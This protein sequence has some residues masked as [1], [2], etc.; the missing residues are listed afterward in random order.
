MKKISFY[1]KKYWYLYLLA[2]FCLFIYEFLDMVSPKVTQSIID[3]VITDGQTNLLPILI[4]TLVVV[5]VGRVAAG[6]VREFTFDKTS[7]KVASDIRKHLFGHVQSL[8]VD[9][10]DKMNTGEIMSRVKDD[11]DKLQGAFGFIGMMF[12]QVVIHTV[13]ILWCMWQISP[14]LTIFPIIA[15]PLC[16]TIAIVME[17]KL[18]KVYEEISD[19]DADMN[20]V[21]EENLTG[22]RVVKAFAREKFEIT[23]FLKHNKRYYDLNM[24]QS[25]VWIKYN[26]LM[27][28]MTKMLIVVALLL[29]GLKVINGEMS[30]GALGAF[31]EYCANAVWP[32]EMLGWLSN[33]LASAFASKK[34]LDKIYAETAKIRDPEGE[35]DEGVKD[36]LENFEFKN[37]EFKNVSFSMENKKILENVSFKLEKGRTLGIMGATGSGKTTIINMLL[38]FYDPEKGKILLNGV[39]IRELPLAVVRRNASVVMQ[40]V[41]LFSDTIDENIR[42]GNKDGITNDDISEALKKACASGFVGKLEEGTETVIGERGVGLSG[43]QKQR[44][45]M[46]RAFAKHAPVLVLDDST[47]ALDMETEHEVQ[48]NLSE[49]K[50]STKIIIAHRISAVRHADEIIVL[51]N[52]KIS[53]RGNHESLLDKKGYYY[54]T[55]M[56]QYGDVLKQ[57][58]NAN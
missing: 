15:L 39:D 23:K 41:F 21:A 5:G 12:L 48:E 3:D 50:N 29:G 19:E 16:A 35:P 26:P 45:S 54:K 57:L 6:Y 32:M 43:G 2:L 34:K 33:E 24:K 37:L 27:Q 22:V 56:A 1:L 38:R 4:I 51:E 28:M 55:Y 36:L 11:V 42:L 14:F 30:L 25:K 53:E 18:D 13:M 7:F 10:F 47:S 44:I 20:T 31:L 8:S 40:D 49:I 46:A 58:E 17:R 52:G 9:Y